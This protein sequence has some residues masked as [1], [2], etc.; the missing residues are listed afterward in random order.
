MRVITYTIQKGYIWSLKRHKKA[1]LHEFILHIPYALYFTVAPSR[2][3][4]NEFLQKGLSG[5]GQSATFS[6]EPFEVSREEYD[7]ILTAWKETN[8]RLILKYKIEDIP[9]LSLVLDD[10]IMSI[11][12]HADYLKKS[13]EKY[14]SHFFAEN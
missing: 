14:Q 4:L 2:E 5:G 13:R 10:K 6:W 11:E 12:R 1:L 9:D 7:E 3:A 8:L